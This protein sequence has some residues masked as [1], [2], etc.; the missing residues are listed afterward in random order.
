PLHG[1][2][3]GRGRR[4]RPRR[5]APGLRPRMT[6]E[7][8]GVLYALGAFGLWGM[9]PLYWRLLAGT[10]AHEILLHR[11]AWSAFFLA[12]VMR[13]RLGELKKAARTPRVALTL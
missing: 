4:V 10:P 3:T 1:R 2:R 12:F 11:I 5:R 6:R 9:S 7:T 8:A 13:G